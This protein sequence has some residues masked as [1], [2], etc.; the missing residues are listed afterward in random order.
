VISSLAR[1]ARST[2]SFPFAF[3]P[4][5]VDQEKQKLKLHLKDSGDHDV[6][7]PR[8]LVDGGL[9][10]N[11]PFRG[12][13]QAIFQMPR[14]GNVR[15]VLAYI[16]PDPGDGPPGE[17]G[18]DMPKLASVLAASIMGIPQSQ[19]IADQLQAIETHNKGVRTRRDSV[20]DL[21]QSLEAETLRDLADK[22]FKV[23]RKR[24][25]SN[26]FEIFVHAAL[27]E[28][29]RRHPKWQPGLQA[30]G[31]RGREQLKRTFEEIPW[32]GW[33]PKKW[34]DSPDHPQNRL[35]TWEWGLFPV[36]FSVKVLLDLLRLAQS[37][38]D[39]ASAMPAPGFAAAATTTTTTATSP[40]RAGD[41]ADSG[42]STAQDTSSSTLPARK[43]VSAMLSTAWKRA[44]QQG[45][46]NGFHRLARGSGGSS[47]DV[48]RRS[49]Q[50]RG[51]P[52]RR[53][54]S[55]RHA[56]CPSGSTIASLGRSVCVRQKADRHSPGGNPRLERQ[57]R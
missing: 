22:L 19:A 27:P 36:E 57:H 17:P 7:M 28:A 16:N 51:P 42:A 15:R 37:L 14:Y 3:E 18:E 24:R 25:L 12:A 40:N 6:S 46:A 8:Y 1:A 30:L 52:G 34:P 35:Y 48:G 33:I 53:C 32:D 31:N 39:Y 4:S 29:V 47:A 10:D 55:S 23:Y 11:K 20:L 2:A 54:P 21:V 49:P 13:L 45:P 43:A 9:L 50:G 38:S 41:W 56:R 26:T 5:L 44:A